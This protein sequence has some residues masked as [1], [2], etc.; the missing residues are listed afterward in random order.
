MLFSGPEAESGGSPI[1]GGA[2][3][4]V[5]AVILI[6]VMVIVSIILIILLVRWRINS[7]RIKGS[8]SRYGDDIKEVYLDFILFFI[9]I[10]VGIDEFE[11]CFCEIFYCMK[12]FY[13]SFFF[14]LRRIIWMK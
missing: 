9:I 7:L 14:F 2:T 12:Y 8:S 5:I 13:I 6:V 10:F 3:W 11:L 1:P 4:L